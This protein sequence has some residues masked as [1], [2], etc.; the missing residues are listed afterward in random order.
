MA[1]HGS[2]VRGASLSDLLSF[3]GTF[4]GSE[5]FF[6]T[7]KSAVYEF[8]DYEAGPFCLQFIGSHTALGS[9][10][11]EGGTKYPL[12]RISPIDAENP[13]SQGVFTYERVSVPAS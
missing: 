7:A 12:Y 11:R 5:N 1:K 4:P 8:T 13:D 10:V 3:L 6:V 2:S 9:M